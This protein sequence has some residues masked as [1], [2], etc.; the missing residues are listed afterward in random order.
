MQLWPCPLYCVNEFFL[1]SQYSNS[2]LQKTANKQT[3]EN[4]N[5]KTAEFPLVLRNFL[6]LPLRSLCV[7]ILSCIIAHCVWS[8]F[9]LNMHKNSSSKCA[10]FYLLPEV[11]AVTIQNHFPFSVNCWKQASQIQHLTHQVYYDDGDLNSASCNEGY[12]HTA[13]QLVKPQL[14]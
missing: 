11:L 10:I 1:L 2:I 6:P 8:F 12:N 4:N 7:M 14:G 5:K 9:F 3:N 13:A